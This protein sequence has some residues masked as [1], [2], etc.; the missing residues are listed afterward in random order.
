MFS[1]IRR[2]ATEMATHLVEKR[3]ELLEEALKNLKW[4]SIYLSSE[5]IKLIENDFELMH[6]K[7][8]LIKLQAL[9]EKENDEDIGPKIFEIEKKIQD[10]IDEKPLIKNN[11]DSVLN[12]WLETKKQTL[13]II[14]RFQKYIENE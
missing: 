12:E 2:L 8:D 4:K 10:L 7:Q 5:K 3:L 1:E 13:E 6:A 9:H 14:E 11:F